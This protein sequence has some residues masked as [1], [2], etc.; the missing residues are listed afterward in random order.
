[1][2]PDVA[3]QTTIDAETLFIHL[4]RRLANRFNRFMEPGY[5]AW[6]QSHA[7]ELWARREAAR[8][9]WDD[10]AVYQDFQAC[11]IPWAEYRR[12]IYQWARVELACI[13]AHRRSLAGVERHA[14]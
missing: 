13:R 6:T 12:L 8:L 9:A 5:L 4:W 11:R 14:A 7:P 10:P 1:M 3:A 2:A